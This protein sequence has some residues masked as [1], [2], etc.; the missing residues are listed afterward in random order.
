MPIQTLTAGSR[1]M[2]RAARRFADRANLLD[3]PLR[4]GGFNVDQWAI[5]EELVD[6]ALTAGVCSH[7]TVE[8]SINELFTQGII[9]DTDHWFAGLDPKI[10]E[11]LHTTWP[12][13]ERARIED[14]IPEAARIVGF[15]TFTFGAVRAS[16][17]LGGETW[18]PHGSVRH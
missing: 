5:S 4:L 12:D 10:A 7:A 16:G 11:N 6:C 13:F 8:A 1:V 15:R 9:N 14:K 17:A 18:P 2:A 3:D